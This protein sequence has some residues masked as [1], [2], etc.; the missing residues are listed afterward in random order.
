[1]SCKVWASASVTKPVSGS[2]ANA[3][4]LNQGAGGRS[5]R[6]FLSLTVTIQEN[7]DGIQGLAG[8]G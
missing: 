2:L 1:M 3:I 4:E 7:G 8:D 5:R 6:A